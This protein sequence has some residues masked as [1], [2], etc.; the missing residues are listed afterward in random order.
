MKWSLQRK[1]LCLLV[2]TVVG[3]ATQGTMGLLTRRTFGEAIES[4]GRKQLPASRAVTLIDMRHDGLLAVVLRSIRAAQL[5]DA[6]EIKSV[7]EDVTEQS[8][9]MQANLDLLKTLSLSPNISAEIER[10]RPAIEKYVTNAQTV[11]HAASSGDAAGAEAKFPEYL[12]AFKELEESLDALGESIEH[13]VDGEVEASLTLSQTENHKALIFFTLCLSLMTV[14]NLLIARS[15][16][17]PIVD[18]AGKFRATGDKLNGC[19]QEVARHGEG[20][21]QRATEQSASLEETVSALSEI[22]ESARKSAEHTNRADEVSRGV[23]NRSEEG[24]RAMNRMSDSL[25][26]MKSSADETATIVRVIEEIAFQTNLLALNAAVEAARAGDA[27]R[28]FAVVAEEVRSLAQRSALAAKDTAEKIQRS[29]EHAED[30]VEESG[31]VSS[32]LELISGDA[33]RAAVLSGDIAGMI[34]QQSSAIATIQS[35]M[36]ELDQVTQMNAAS[37]EEFAAAGGQLLGESR[38]VLDLVNTLETLLH[39]GHASAGWD[40]PATSTRSVPLVSGT[41]RSPRAARASDEFTS[42]DDSDGLHV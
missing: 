11:V 12:A 5:H 30:C 7:E 8:K 14:V 20:L 4:I 23:Q 42:W 32:L 10:T 16:S 40:A 41:R 9:D 35:T 26:L 36:N 27:G 34:R 17:R 6:D 15:V 24:V 25:A 38:T 13:H 21:A 18:C 3:I 19:S 29:K 2:V 28:G 33:S 31:S 37:A 39:G 1:F 22:A